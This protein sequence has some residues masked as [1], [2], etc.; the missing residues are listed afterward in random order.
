MQLNP[1]GHPP[2]EHVE[3]YNIL[4]LEVGGLLHNRLN[5]LLEN[6]CVA[7]IVKQRVVLYEQD[8]I[9]W[10][11]KRVMFLFLRIVAQRS[12]CYTLLNFL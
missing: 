8:D 12:T 5:D 9:R 3:T 1:V 6:W 11:E 10:E 2:V 4:Q 7:E